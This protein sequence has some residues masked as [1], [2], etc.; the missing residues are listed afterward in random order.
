MSAAT[1]KTRACTV[2]A[3]DGELRSAIRAHARAFGL[4]D[5]EDNVLMCCETL[6][7]HPKKGFLGGIRTTLSAVY[8]TPKWL[9]WADSN[10]RNDVAAGT[11][12]LELIDVHDYP[13]SARYAITPDQG[14]TIAGCSTGRDRSGITFIVLD[15]EADGLKFRQVLEQ[16]LRD[17]SG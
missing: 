13:A 4:E 1:R 11:A 16:A 2:E 17:A 7:V 9:A 14:L 12:L 3:L 15:T 10:G 6:T 8:V 5:L